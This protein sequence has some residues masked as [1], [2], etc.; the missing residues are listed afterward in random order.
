MKRIDRARELAKGGLYQ[1]DT[2]HDACGV[3][4]VASI[5][6]ERSHSIVEKGLHALERLAHR[7]AVGSDP[8]TGDGAGILL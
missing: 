7:G 8:L 5:R 1:P 2:E 6:G 4:F 3:A